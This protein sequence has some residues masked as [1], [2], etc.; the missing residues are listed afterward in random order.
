MT[1]AHQVIPTSPSV[2]R[3]LVREVTVQLLHS[4]LTQTDSEGNQADPWPLILAQQEGKIIRS[5]ARA[6]LHLQQNRA[7]RAKPFLH[8][9]GTAL[10]LLENFLEGKAPSKA[11]RQLFGAE[12]SL[13]ALFDLLKRQLK[14]EK[15]PEAI[16][17]TMGRI[18]E[19]NT[20]SREALQSLAESL[21]QP[22]N[23]PQPLV[24]LAKAVNPLLES[25]QLL[26]TLLSPTPPDLRELSALHGAIAERDAVKTE[27]LALHDLILE[28]L[29]ESDRLLA[30]KLENFA[31]D[32]LG[33]VERAVLRLALTEFNHCPDIPSAV[34]INE[35]I[36]I[37]RR[38]G[39]IESAGFVNGLLDKLVP[40]AKQQSD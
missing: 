30:A 18:A 6:I 35:A 15:E 23:C 26:Q 24:T 1:T 20:T 4:S 25:A 3:R 32:R 9:K 16:E 7:G 39:D 13:P 33:K 21:G 36:E 8:S 5:R 22:S 28:H 37:A 17:S 12:E 19:K 31:P 27:S 11:F 38:F 40:A 14:S 2:P 10:P 34:T 29:P